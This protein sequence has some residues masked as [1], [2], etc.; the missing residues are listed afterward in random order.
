MPIAAS[1]GGQG[2]KTRRNLVMRVAGMV[3]AT[4]ILVVG[5]VNVDEEPRSAGATI[6]FAVL[7]LA[8]AI[9]ARRPRGAPYTV[10]ENGEPM[11]AIPMRPVSLRVSLGLAIVGVLV[12]IGAAAGAW[13]ALPDNPAK[14][15][16]AVVMGGGL[17]L[18][19]GALGL[20]NLLPR[21]RKPRPVLLSDDGVSW[22]FGGERH[23]ARWDEI[24]SVEPWWTPVGYGIIRSTANHILLRGADG[25]PVT[26]FRVALLAVDPDLALGAIRESKAGS[27]RTL[28]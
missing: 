28:E 13:R 26:T 15:A 24:A 19:I 17:G 20:G 8:L 21:V 6:A 5:L 2:W 25:E 10:V 14:A 7:L 12:L 9:P 22:V 23:L 11:V 18:L 16:A 3:A 1:A 27:P 4:L